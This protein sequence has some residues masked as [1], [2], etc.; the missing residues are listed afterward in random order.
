MNRTFF[1]SDPHF[2]HQKVLDY[3]QRPFTSV[4][5][6]NKQLITNWNNVVS[7][8]DTVYL[9]GDIAFHLKK[10][11]VTNI[12]QQLQGKKILILGN[13]DRRK[14]VSWWLD[15]GFHTVSEYPILYDWK[16]LLSHEPVQLSPDMPYLNLHGHLH[17]E[18][19]NSHQH[20]CLSVEQTR[21]R[22]IRLEQ[23]EKRIARNRE[24]ELVV[25]TIV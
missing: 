22:P 1:Y 10:E 20:I 23:V 2:G 3:E 11:E 19:H 6:M 9:L 17:S 14:S 21:Y 25:P 16:Y 7:K 24:K 15:V 5:H 8:G 18:Q 12:I 4:D 13:H